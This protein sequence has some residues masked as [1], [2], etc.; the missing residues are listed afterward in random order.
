MS[1]SGKVTNIANFGVFVEL[2]DGVDGLIHISELNRGKKKGLNIAIGDMVEAEV[3][4]VDP[5]E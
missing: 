1:I 3:L 5:Q 2:E 4:N